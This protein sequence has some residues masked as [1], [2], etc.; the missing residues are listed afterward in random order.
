MDFPLLLAP[1]SPLPLHRQVYL[2]IRAAVLDGRL[3]RGQRIP[4]TRALAGL[5]QISRTTASVA[6]EQLTG[7]GYLE[8]RRGSGTYVAA[9]LPE[10]YLPPPT[11]PARPASAAPALSRFGARLAD[12]DP[13][14]RPA[15]GLPYDFSPG[16][17]A[18]DAFPLDL[19]GRLLARQCRAASP[20]Q[21]GYGADP[22][23]HGPLREALAEYLRRSRAV[24]CEPEQV[25]VLSG[26]Q[27]ALDLAARVLV[28]PGETVAM[29]DPG[30]PG[31]RRCFLAHGA[32]LLPLPVGARGLELDALQGARPR[33]VYLTPSH[34]YPTGRVLDLPRRLALLAWAREQGARQARGPLLFEDDYDSEFRFEG[35]PLPAMQG[36]DGAG[37]VL[38]SG[39]FSKV[40]FPALRL[41]YLVVPPALAQPMA[42]ALAVSC[43]Q[44]PVMEQAALAEAIRE[45]H[46]E[47]HLRR[48]RA[49]Y[50]ARREALVAALSAHFSDRVTLLG[51]NGGMQL[52]A[53][54]PATGPDAQLVRRA[55]ALGVGL[56]PAS[57]CHL[58]PGP[59]QGFLLGFSALSPARIREGVRR[60]ASLF[61]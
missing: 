4:S 33:L 54:F 55:A 19:W 57:Q 30:Y 51:A 31:A 37:T 49:L 5:L 52:L 13:P 17:P 32:R 23:G 53:Q 12:L 46:F 27:Q 21:L 60:L 8:A 36:L 20:G 44:P 26:T 42:R 34:Q 2:G 6:C 14:P 39:T 41:G 40:L 22:A 18:L 45:G 29:E 1:D 56:S 47:R 16:C 3:G 25:L 50:G 59:G 38:Y 11:A 43:R 24:R 10:D 7:E 15:A 9:R 61:H 35:R 58:V 28:D 48:M